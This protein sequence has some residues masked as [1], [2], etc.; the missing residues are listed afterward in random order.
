MLLQWI[1]PARKC[2]GHS[3]VDLNQHSAL[4]WTVSSLQVF[5]LTCVLQSI[6]HS[7]RLLLALI[8]CSDSKSQLP[9][10]TPSWEW[11]TDP[12][13]WAVSLSYD[14]WQVRCIKWI[15][16]HLIYF[17]L[18]MGLSECSPIVSQR[19]SACVIEVMGILWDAVMIGY[20]WAPLS[21]RHPPVNFP[22]GRDK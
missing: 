10:A 20:L 16:I 13:Q 5:M 22:K 19:A 11:T 9:V 12:L 17:Q 8:L 6:Y 1:K 21:P 18:M 14:V 3:K 4:S 15:L 7:L 2:G